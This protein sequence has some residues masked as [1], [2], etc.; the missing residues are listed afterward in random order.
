[1]EKVFELGLDCE[2]TNRFEPPASED[3][4]LADLEAVSFG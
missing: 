3:A 2:N 4:E 1:V